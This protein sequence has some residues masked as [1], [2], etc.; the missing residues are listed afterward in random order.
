[1]K[2]NGPEDLVEITAAQ[3]AV[4]LCMEGLAANQLEGENMIRQTLVDGTALKKF[5]QILENQGKYCKILLKS[6]IP[7]P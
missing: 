3:G 7:G 2:G 1:M 5:L 6:L 4:I